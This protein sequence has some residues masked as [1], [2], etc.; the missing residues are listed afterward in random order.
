MHQQ[1]WEAAML[2]RRQPHRTYTV[3]SF[4][5]AGDS[6]ERVTQ[7]E[8]L[9]GRLLYMGPSE[10]L[11]AWQFYQAAADSL[12]DPRAYSIL[13]ERDREVIAHVRPL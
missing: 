3:Y 11:A 12:H 7:P 13:M 10:R 9:T 4:S 5:A 6:S 2:R 1:E 8:Q